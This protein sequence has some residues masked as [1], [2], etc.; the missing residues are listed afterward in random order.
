RLD[1]DE[2]ADVDVGAELRTRP[3]ARERTDTR[4]IPYVRALDVRER[5]DHRAILHRHAGAK[6]DVRL[7][8]DVFSELGVGREEYGV[9][10]DEC[11]AG[12]HRRRAQALLQHGFGFGELRLGVDAAHVVL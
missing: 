4:T 3:Q 11:H 9:G 2:V 5:A 8:G 6:H 1:L 10:R 7:D 12:L